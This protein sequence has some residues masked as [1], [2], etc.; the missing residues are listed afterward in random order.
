MSYHKPIPVAFPLFYRCVVYE[1]TPLLQYDAVNILLRGFTMNTV[2]S[3]G[4]LI[5]PP[6]IESPK[7]TAYISGKR[8]VTQTLLNA[9]FDCSHDEIVR[10]M[11]ELRLVNI[12]IAIR[13]LAAVVS[14]YSPF[15]TADNQRFKERPASPKDQYDYL[16]DFFVLALNNTRYGTR[17]LSNEELSALSSCNIFGSTLPML[18]EESPDTPAT[19]QKTDTLPAAPAAFDPSTDSD[20]KLEVHKV[21]T[22]HDAH[23]SGLDTMASALLQFSNTLSSVSESKG[24]PVVATHYSGSSAETAA[25]YSGSSADD[26]F[27]EIE[28]GDSDNIEPIPE[29]LPRKFDPQDWGLLGSYLST[30]QVLIRSGIIEM[31]GNDINDMQLVQ[32]WLED[33]FSKNGIT[34]SRYHNLPSEVMGFIQLFYKGKR[35]SLLDC[36][37]IQCD[38]N[39]LYF[40]VKSFI[41]NGYPE[42]LVLAELP[43]QIQNGEA[44]CY[45][46]ELIAEPFET[47]MSGFDSDY[48]F[49]RTNEKLSYDVVRVII[50]AYNQS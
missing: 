26:G 43:K 46:K 20:S 23:G 31:G 9:I 44:T 47:V 24:I 30:S 16:A 3:N 45:N 42:M 22:T 48:I 1:N 29:E 33:W 38:V 6:S 19:V 39:G 28:D 27:E 12:E 21:V 8:K 37:E 32:L 4:V 36:Y 50:L 34:D 49:V 40:I 10:R 15:S 17:I 2:E 13:R 35:G 11:K 5:E 14:D 18:E 7:C 41:P 25:L